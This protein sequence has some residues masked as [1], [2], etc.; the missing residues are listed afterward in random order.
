MIMAMIMAPM[1]HAL[2]AHS[3]SLARA[4]GSG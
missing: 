2:G 1:T 4:W 3:R